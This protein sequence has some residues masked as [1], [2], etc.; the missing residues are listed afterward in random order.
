MPKGNLPRMIRRLFHITVALVLLALAIVCFWA[1]LEG[2]ANG[3]VA[4]ATRGSRSVLERS[5]SPIGYWT[6]V[7]TWLGAG[8]GS[9]WASLAA[10]RKARDR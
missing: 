9:L 7:L 4:A 3:E 5:T 2:L 1:G 6:D 8:F 10:S